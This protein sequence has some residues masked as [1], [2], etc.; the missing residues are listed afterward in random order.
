MMRAI[1]KPEYL[2]HGGHGQWTM[3]P[4][5]STAP[6]IL[7]A[8]DPLHRTKSSDRAIECIILGGSDAQRDDECIPN[9]EHSAA[10]DKIVRQSHR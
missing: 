7:L 9:G 10:Q 6:E 3:Q 1:T 2:K 5:C 8:H 4:S